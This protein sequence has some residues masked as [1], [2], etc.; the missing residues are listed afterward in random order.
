MWMER[1]TILGHGN[2]G[3]KFLVRMHVIVRMRVHIDVV[4][5]EKNSTIVKQRAL[6]TIESHPL[7]L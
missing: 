7:R 2:K 5:K 4:E 3:A 6:T 1:I